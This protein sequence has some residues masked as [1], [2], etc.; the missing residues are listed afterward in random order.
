MQQTTGYYVASGSVLVLLGVLGYLQTGT[1]WR[2]VV[3]A[4]LY[5]VEMHLMTRPTFPAVLTKVLNPLL[6]MTGWHPPLLP[7]QFLTLLRKISVTFFIAL[8]QLGPLLLGAQAGQSG[9]GVSSQ[10]LDRLDAVSKAADQE[11]SRMMGLE[12]SPYTTDPASMREL[13]SGLREWLVQNTIRN[14]PEVSR[15]VQG[16]LDRRR[17]GVEPAG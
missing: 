8:A 4:S 7:F 16:V 13:R 9:D 10:Q 1:F 14:D 17:Q 5:V 12:M 6:N 15:A 3:M 11:V 2:Y